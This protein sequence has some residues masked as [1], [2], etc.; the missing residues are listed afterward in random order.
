MVLYHAT[1]PRELVVPR[2]LPATMSDLWGEYK[3]TKVPERKVVVE[4]DLEQRRNQYFGDE[5]DDK[6][7]SLVTSSN[8]VHNNPLPH[9]IKQSKYFPQ[10]LY[11]PAP[12]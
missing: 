9:R 6:R 5:Y 3:K 1:V 11:R 12:L 8:K 2:L 4:H 10:A 7:K